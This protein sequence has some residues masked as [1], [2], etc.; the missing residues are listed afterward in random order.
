MSSWQSSLFFFL[1]P[2]YLICGFKWAKIRCISLLFVCIV[3]AFMAVEEEVSVSLEPD[4]TELPIPEEPK[5]SPSGRWLVF[6]S[7]AHF[8]ILTFPFTLRQRSVPSTLAGVICKNLF[9]DVHQNAK[10]TEINMWMMYTSCL[11][12]ELDIILVVFCY[13]DIVHIKPC[14]L[15]QSIACTWLH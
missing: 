12:H 10:M 13:F 9:S 3:G 6:Y 7:V 11:T 8:S 14:F 2:N 5:E 1:N 15:A 4:N